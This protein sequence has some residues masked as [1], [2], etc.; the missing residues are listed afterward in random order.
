TLSMSTSNWSPSTAPNYISL[1]WNYNGQPVN[2]NGYVGVTFT[3]NV[4][5]SIAGISSFG[6]DI[7]LVGS[8]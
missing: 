4:S 3:L 7:N 6:F 8:G 2:P 5:G 1:N